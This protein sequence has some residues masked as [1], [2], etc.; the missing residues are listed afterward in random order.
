MAFATETK[1]FPASLPTSTPIL[2]V[3]RPLP[4]GRMGKLTAGEY[5]FLSSVLIGLL[6]AQARL[7][8]AM[9]AV[10]RLELGLVLV[11][12]P[13][14]ALT[15]AW[16]VHE[17]GHLI[18]A[19]LAGF[20]VALVWPPAGSGSQALPASGALRVGVLLLQPPA[21]QKLRLRLASIFVSGP[22][23]GLVFATAIELVQNRAQESSLFQISVHLIAGF[24]V[25]F[26]MASLLPDTS[27]HGNFSDG[28]RLLMLLRNDAKATRLC[29]VLEMQS[30]LRDGIHPRDW[31]ATLVQAATCSDDNSRDSVIGVWF[32]YLWASERQ[33]IT[34][35]TR[36]LEDALA[37]PSACPAWLR[38]RLHLEAAVFQAWFRD[39]P[40]KARSW[41]AHIRNEKLFR[42]EQTRLQIA[43][44]WAEG[45]LFDAFEKLPDYIAALRE[46]QESP[47]RDLREKSALD[48]KH[49]MESRM[50]SRAWHSM[51]NLSQQ[52]EFSTSSSLISSAR[53]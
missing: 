26:S 27:R 19:W 33:D 32:A 22:A 18:G 1:A 47:A 36:F 42:F 40:A 7:S 14:A 2:D 48:W 34:S 37:V 4:S 24:S 28:A 49:Q 44:L 10:S 41:A 9:T 15:T 51:Y 20:R 5:F 31:P 45:R 46:L 12:L 53:Y 11:F 38:D 17:A 25:L 23:A 39:N 50:L 35:A 8:E 16:L 29:A 30:F 6:V 3:L 13:A 52:V 43:L 21:V